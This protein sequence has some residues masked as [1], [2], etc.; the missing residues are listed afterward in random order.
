MFENFGI[1]EKIGDPP[2]P[3]PKPN[4]G[5]SEKQNNWNKFFFRVEIQFRSRDAIF[6]SG[7]TRFRRVQRFQVRT[8]KV[9]LVVF[10]AVVVAQ[11]SLLTSEHHGSN[12]SIG[13]IKLYQC[14]YS[15]N[16]EKQQAGSSPFY[17]LLT[18]WGAMAT[19]VRA[20]GCRASGPTFSSNA[21]LCS[22][23]VIGKNLKPKNIFGVSE[24]RYKYMLNI[25]AA[26]TVLN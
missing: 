20:L 25:P 16:L 10:G 12:P 1:S 2:K 5:L 7:K 13:K 22:G 9:K 11:R 15:N 21:L 24:F 6:R 23:E 17:K 3:R 14:F 8:L 4:K 18:F 26:I 19:W